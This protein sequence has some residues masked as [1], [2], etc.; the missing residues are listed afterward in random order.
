M[1]NI[2]KASVLLLSSFLLFSHAF[3]NEQPKAADLVG[4]A[5]GGAHLLYM[6]TDN[7]RLLTADSLSNIDH[8]SGLG[9]ELGYRMS[10]FAEFRFSFSNINLVKENRGLI[11]PRV[12]QRPLN[13]LFFL[14][15]K[16]FTS[17]VV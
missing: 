5:Y 2:Y 7:D 4:K 15:S 3:A 17:S 10:E 12:H 8:G 11:H 1:K 13:F 6:N 16:V 9:L 14:Q